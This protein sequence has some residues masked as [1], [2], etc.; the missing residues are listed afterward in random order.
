MGSD[1]G[2]ITWRN[3]LKTGDLSPGFVTDENRDS[4]RD[5]F[6]DYGAWSREEVEEWDDRE[7]AALIVQEVAAEI[8]RLQ[9]HEGLD[10]AELTE[11]VELRRACENEGGRFFPESYPVTKQTNWYYQIGF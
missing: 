3:A 4:I 2:Q 6:H 9:E 7:L 5:H 8:R 11:E 1:A 10:L